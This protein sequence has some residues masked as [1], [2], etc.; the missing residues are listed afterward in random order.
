MHLLVLAA[1]TQS[2]A[3]A[4]AEKLVG[5]SELGK[6]YVHFILLLSEA[7]DVQLL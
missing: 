2:S 1:S 4:L 5:S 6:M 3:P 7:V